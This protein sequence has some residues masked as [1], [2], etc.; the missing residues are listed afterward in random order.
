[1]IT[2]EKCKDTRRIRIDRIAQSACGS[3]G[4][5]RTVIDEELISPIA[6]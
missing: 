1:V 6:R 5:A 2:L 3:M 4:Q